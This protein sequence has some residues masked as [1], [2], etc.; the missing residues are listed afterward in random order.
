MDVMASYLG[1]NITF[2]NFNTKWSY[3]KILIDWVRS[4]RTGKYFALGSY[5]LTSSQISFRPALPLSQF[6]LRKAPF[7]ENYMCICIVW[8]NRSDRINENDSLVP[9]LGLLKSRIKRRKVCR[10]ITQRT[11]SSCFVPWLTNNTWKTEKKDSEPRLR[12]I[13]LGIRSTSNKTSIIHF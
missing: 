9:V 10:F 7:S 3:D 6:K 2:Q 1:S 8:R 11:S 12:N 13:N 5:V 4:Y